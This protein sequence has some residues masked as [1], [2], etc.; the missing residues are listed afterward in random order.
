MI[1]LIHSETEAGSITRNLG[2]SEYSYYFVLKEFRPLLESLGLVVAVSDPASEV[3]RLWANARVHGEDCIFLTFSPPHRTYVPKFCP[4][5]PLFAWEFDSL[6][7][8]TW[9]DDPRHDWRTVL[10]Q[11]GGAITHSRFAVGVVQAAMR[12]DYPIIS[13]P[14]PVWDHFAPL[15]DPASTGLTAPRTIQV[16]GRVYDTNG[17]DLTPYT[18]FSR[19]LHGQ[20][21]LPPAGGWL[22]EQSLTLSGVVYTTVF[23]PAD[24]RK[25]WFDMICAFVWALRDRADAT[26]VMKL[27]YRDAGNMVL[28]MLGDLAKLGTYQCRIVIIDGYL[29]DD[30]YRDLAALS[31]YTVN[32]ST[33]EGQCLPL[34]EYLSAGK[35]AVTPAHT[36]MADYIT[37]GNA[38]IVASDHEPGIWPH[39]PREAVRTRRHRLEFDSLVAAYAESYETAKGNPARYRAMAAA[40]HTDL[41][42]H[43]ARDVILPALMDFMRKHAKQPA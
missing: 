36:A 12:A 24:G 25:N 2:V 13:L 41:Q 33:G 17:L 1:Y 32:T 23:C 34:M 6:P 7:N 27:T 39:D 15:Y 38:F 18:P 43:C 21:P 11:T 37:P 35:P 30:A 22:D 8:E 5:I 31:S 4:T 42:R 40:A 3:D 20:A 14:A 19:R 26:L 16:R 9:N 10:R 28:A 29:P